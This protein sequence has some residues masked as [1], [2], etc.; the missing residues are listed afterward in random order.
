MTGH[1]GVPAGG[2]GGSAAPPAARAM[3]AA[4]QAN[5][6]FRARE[7]HLHQAN[8]SGRAWKWRTATEVAETTTNYTNNNIQAGRHQ[9][10]FWLD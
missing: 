1:M 6:V 10:L 7:F 8:N 4:G 5:D 2:A 3:K 9:D